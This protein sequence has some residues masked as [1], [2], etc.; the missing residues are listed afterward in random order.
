MAQ[1]VRDL[2]AQILLRVGFTQTQ[3]EDILG[4]PTQWEEVRGELVHVLEAIALRA[5]R[6][7]E[8]SGVDK[9][10][11]EIRYDFLF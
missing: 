11:E 10:P 1:G 3:V 5:R 6:E 4:T 7:A 9:D 8:E 2:F